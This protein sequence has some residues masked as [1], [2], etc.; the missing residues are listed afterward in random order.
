MVS[1]EEN[2]RE[3][4]RTRKR[5]SEREK[6]RGGREKEK[7]K[8]KEKEI[9]N[10]QKPRKANPNLSIRCSGIGYIKSLHLIVAD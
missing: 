7:E 4:R 9:D 10:I 6:E 2:E 3:E 5:E 1:R 8:E